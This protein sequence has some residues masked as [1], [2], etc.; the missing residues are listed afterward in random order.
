MSKESKLECHVTV[1]SSEEVDGAKRAAI[2]D[3]MNGI[4]LLTFIGHF[5]ED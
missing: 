2:Q 4:V 5:P 3:L 1:G